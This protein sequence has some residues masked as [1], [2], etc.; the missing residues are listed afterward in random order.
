MASLQDAS[1]MGLH[2]DINTVTITIPN[3]RQDLLQR[4]GSVVGS[5]PARMGGG[6]VSRH[7]T[8][9]AALGSGYEAP[10]SSLPTFQCQFKCPPAR[11]D[12]FR[13]AALKIGLH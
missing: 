8:L 9:R 13:Q 10:K 11:P 6:A 3:P 12:R 1:L 2:V 4:R 5:S 7:S